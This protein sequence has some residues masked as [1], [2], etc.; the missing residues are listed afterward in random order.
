MT[1]TNNYETLQTQIRNNTIKQI[2]VEREIS[3]RL[4]KDSFYHFVRYMWTVIEPETKF[5]DGWHIKTLCEHAEAVTRFEIKKL[6]VNMPPRHMKSIIWCVMWPA[7]VWGKN[8]ERSFIFGSHSLTLATR[9]SIKTRQLIN[10]DEYRNVFDQTWTLADDQDQ[11]T[12]FKNTRGGVRKSVG[13]GSA[14]TGEG[15]D[16]LVVDDPTNALE[17]HSELAREEA[18]RWWDT[19][20]ST[21]INN[22]KR[23]AKVIIMQRL[24]EKDLSGHVMKTDLEFERLIL[25]ARFNPDSK[26]KSKTSLNFI[27]PRTKK[28]ELLWGNQWDEASIKDAEAR[29]GDDA[30]AQLDQEPKTP[31]G[32]FFPPA[33]WKYY[34]ASPS[35][36]LSTVLFVDAAQKPGVSNDYSVYALWARTQNGYYLLDLMREKTDGPLLEELT[37][38]MCARWCIDEVIIEDKSAGSSLIQYLLNYTSLPVTPF[39]PGRLSKEVRAAAAKPTVKAGKCYLPEKPIMGT[40]DGKEVNLIEVFVEEHEKFLKAA[41]DDTVDT[42]SMMVKHFNTYELVQPGIRS[43][44]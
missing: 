33:Y 32:G 12:V 16:Y 27:D 26:L 28:G 23:Y 8:P 34:K 29:L 21:R 43:L 14:V 31:G 6:N 11:K 44:V 37:I 22:P 2:A 38:Q 30:S 7:W 10:S 25:S 35:E 42:T 19:V 40:E 13:V 17:A 24:H 5:V 3:R 39:N 15:A 9:D 18:I 20:L 36:I 1:T 41:H 4:A